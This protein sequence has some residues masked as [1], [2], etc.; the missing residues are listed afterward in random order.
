M[1][2]LEGTPTQED[3]VAVVRA[4]LLLLGFPRVFCRVSLGGGH[5]YRGIRET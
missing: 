5:R 3:R 4:S 2:A 1:V